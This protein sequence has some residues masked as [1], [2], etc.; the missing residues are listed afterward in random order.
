MATPL[1]A[2]SIELLGVELHFSPLRSEE[3]L[4]GN[5]GRGPLLSTGL[6]QRSACRRLIRQPPKMWLRYVGGWWV[7]TLDTHPHDRGGDLENE[8][9]SLT[10]RTAASAARRI[11]WT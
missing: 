2:I 8:R 9:R 11:W 10:Q 7:L 5:A 4:A 1:L 6:V 3:A